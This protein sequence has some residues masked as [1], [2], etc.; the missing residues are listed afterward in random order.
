MFRERKRECVGVCVYS[1]KSK[2]IYV[3]VI[4]R[5]RACCVCVNA[6]VFM[7]GNKESKSI[8]CGKPK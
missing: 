2:C 7:R 6:N 8:L 5:V 1:C 3:I 4:V